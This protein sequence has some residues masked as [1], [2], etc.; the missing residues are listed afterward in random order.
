M[1]HPA[2]PPGVPKTTLASTACVMTQAKSPTL[3]YHLCYNLPWVVTP[4]IE[5][6]TKQTVVKTEHFTAV[7]F[8]HF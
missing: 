7:F 1:K 3:S 5:S 2:H 6:N 8:T 4:K